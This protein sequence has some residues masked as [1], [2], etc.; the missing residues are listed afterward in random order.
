MPAARDLLLGV[1]GGVPAAEKGVA[2][3]SRF[4]SE[5][6]FEES[7][8]F[9]RQMGFARLHAFPFSAR[10]GT[11]AAD[12]PHQI[13]PAVKRQRMRR[14][15]AVAGDS[16][17]QFERT[18]VHSTAQVLWEYQ[19]RGAWHGMTDN[20]LRVVVETDEDLAHRITPVHLIEANGS[21][22]TCE[23]AAAPRY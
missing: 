9:A 14:I 17:R 13:T 11:E 18:H 23:L 22:L 2:W 8:E 20:Y 16:Q 7:V 4:E 12:L 10:S 15:L 19:R 21:G 3:L 6:E 1:L 5:A